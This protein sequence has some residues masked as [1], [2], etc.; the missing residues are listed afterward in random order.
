MYSGDFQLC[1]RTHDPD[2]YRAC[3]LIWES[4]ELRIR[5][6][7]P[8][9]FTFGGVKKVVVELGPDS[10]NRS[11]YRELLNVGLLH[12]P[13]FDVAAFLSSPPQE[14]LRELQSLVAAAMSELSKIFN[15]PVP[16]LQ[17][18]VSESGR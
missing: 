12:Y 8:K 17:S 7:I 6:A 15:T 1:L 13:N 2:Q 14:Q 5:K 16:W 4:L 10:Q 3:Q 18:A 11:H 9:R